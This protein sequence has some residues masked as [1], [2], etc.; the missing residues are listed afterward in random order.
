MAR[1]QLSLFLTTTIVLLTCGLVGF[2]TAGKVLVVP[3]DGSHWLSM[4]P[5]V[6]ALIQKGHHA[7][8]IVPDIN[9][10]LRTSQD[11][12]VKFYPVSY[13]IQ[14]LQENF[15][16][17]SHELFTQRPLL[18][19]FLEL[20]K[21]FKLGAAFMLD[22]CAQLLNNSPLIQSL[23]TMNFDV[24]FTD[25]ILPCGQI[26]ADHLSVPSVFF[27]RGIPCH[28][29]AEAS[30]CPIP[31]S[32]VPRMLTSLTDHMNFLQ[33]CFLEESRAGAPSLV[34]LECQP[35][36]VDSEDSRRVYVV[37]SSLKVHSTVERHLFHGALHV[38]GT[39]IDKYN[40]QE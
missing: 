9:L 20:Q 10:H 38:N 8:V 7:V 28:L 1:K 29:D 19:K 26:L 21:I 35:P 36:Q 22:N 4:R 31:L 24:V 17:M 18:E 12:E 15:F 11:Y 32:Y 27:L 33:R 3:V 30:K 25:V 16:S 6:D 14:Q 37:H 23:E 5:V 13:T 40:K 34:N 2:V 39:N